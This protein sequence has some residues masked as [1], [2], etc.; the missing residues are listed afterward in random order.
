MYF[1]LQFVINEQHISGSTV[2]CFLCFITLLIQV[3]C[4]VIFWTASMLNCENTCKVFSESL[5]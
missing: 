4:A 1:L 2:V 3:M 5:Q